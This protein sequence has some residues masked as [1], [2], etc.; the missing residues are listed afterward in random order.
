MDILGLGTYAVDYLYKVDKLP[1]A[2]GFCIVKSSEVQP[3]GSGCNII[4]Q[5]ARL[6]AYC[7]YICKM[8]DDEA[9]KHV[10]ESLQTEGIDISSVKYLSGGTSLST[11]IVIDDQGD[12][13]I[14]LNQGNSIL[15]LQP[16]D[17]NE[18]V[19]E[20]A[21]VFFT[22]LIPYPAAL[23]GLRLAKHFGHSTV[24]NMQ[25]GLNTMAALG[26]TKEDI[27]AALPYIDVFA[28]CREGL[29]DLSE[30]EDIDGSVAYIRKYFSGLLLV[31]LGS[32]GS[33]S[34]APDGKQIILPAVPVEVIDTTGAGDSYLGAFI[35]AY[36]IEKKPL[37]QAM[38]FASYCAAYTCSGL[39]ARSSPTRIQ[40]RNVYEDKQDRS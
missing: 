32:H 10:L 26:I 17:L 3:G 28:P 35:K 7:G 4:V 23:K 39:G 31:T 22:D 1:K 16:E 18:K 37:E 15:A 33:T 21:Q 8:G 27:L 34:F 11:M 40:L 12:K 20:S 2:D 36:L 30:N 6:G 13:F 25:V 14:M 24:C 9:G 29:F 38:S 19:F 5:A